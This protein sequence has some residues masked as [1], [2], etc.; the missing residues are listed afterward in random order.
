MISLVIMAGL[1]EEVGENS[2]SPWTGNSTDRA[3]EGEDHLNPGI[4]PF[5]C[6]PEDEVDIFQ[7]PQI[8]SGLSSTFP[9]SHEAGVAYVLLFPISRWT[10]WSREV[11]SLHW[12]WHSSRPVGHCIPLSSAVPGTGQPRRYAEKKGMKECNVSE[13]HCSQSSRFET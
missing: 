2:Y 6:L 13:A 3:P 10:L 4:A 9:P 7:F 12:D 5:I 8:S 11:T 1:R